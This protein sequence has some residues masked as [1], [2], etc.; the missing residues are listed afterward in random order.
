MLAAGWQ[1]PPAFA[2]QSVLLAGGSKPCCWAR[3]VPG[4]GHGCA[5]RR[6]FRCWHPAPR[7]ATFGLGQGTS[8]LPWCSAR[9]A[10]GAASCR[11]T[12]HTRGHR[13]CP[14]KKLDGAPSSQRK[15]SHPEVSSLLS[16]ATNTAYKG[17]ILI[18]WDHS[19]TC[20]VSGLLPHWSG[21]NAP[22][23][24]TATGLLTKAGLANEGISTVGG[25]QAEQTLLSP[26]LGLMTPAP[27]PVRQRSQRMLLWQRP[28]CSCPSYC[29]LELC[30]CQGR[31]K[32]RQMFS[33]LLPAC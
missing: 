24:S 7:K 6:W 8:A 11:D 25:T 30:P 33:F 18:K 10:R 28:A 26:K 27:G 5:G 13:V 19:V 16:R 31:H 1:C 9:D 23:H 17:L 2:G 22:A 20:W 14:W 29:F 4:S 3:P 12:I 21:I 32:N 15:P